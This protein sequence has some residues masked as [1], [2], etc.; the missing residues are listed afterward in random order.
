MQN[1]LTFTRRKVGFRDNRGRIHKKKEIYSPQKIHNER[2]HG[3]KTTVKK[4]ANESY[5]GKQ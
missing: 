3:K 1:I 5:D 2:I 4:D